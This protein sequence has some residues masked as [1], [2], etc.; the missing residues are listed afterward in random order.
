MFISFP[1][2]MIYQKDSDFFNLFYNFSF[3]RLSTARTPFEEASIQ[4]L[5]N[6]KRKEEYFPE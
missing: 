5:F 1:K 6:I 3:F 2:K 4:H